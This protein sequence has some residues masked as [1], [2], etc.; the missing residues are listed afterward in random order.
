MYNNWR[1]FLI[2]LFWKTKIITQ[3]GFLKLTKFWGVLKKWFLIPKLW[4]W[5][6]GGGGSV[7]FSLPKK[8]K[9]PLKSF[10]D[11]LLIL[12]G[13]KWFFTS[14]FEVPRALYL[15][16]F[17]LGFE[18]FFSVVKIWILLKFYHLGFKILFDWKISRT[19]FAFHGKFF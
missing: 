2:Y 6:K 17:F 10:L 5:E 4:G 19:Y 14:I 8:K 9:F 16:F 3:I 11:L 15:Y 12:P 13:E 7:F 18:T 1:W